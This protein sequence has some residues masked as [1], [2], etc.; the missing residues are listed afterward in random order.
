MH[1]TKKLLFLF[2][3]FGCFTIY[4]QESKGKEVLNIFTFEEVEE[5]HQQIPKPI[6]VFLYTD[7]CKICFGMKKTTFKNRKVIQFLN[8]KFYFIKLNAEEK[9]DITFLGKI[10]TYKPTGINTGM[11]ELA[12]ELGTIKK[13]IIYPTTIILNTVFEIDAQLTGLYNARKMI[14]ILTAYID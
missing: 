8:E 7:W 2:I 5:I 14:G 11:H 6:L 10:F 1:F 9:Q 13:T 3:F 4:A 12:V